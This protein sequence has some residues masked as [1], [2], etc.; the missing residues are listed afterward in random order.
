MSLIT[1]NAF[2]GL[3]YLLGSNNDQYTKTPNLGLNL[4]DYNNKEQ[5]I[6]IDGK[7]SEI[8]RTTPQLSAVIYKNA[9][10]L[11]NGVFVHYDKN[12]EVI[13]DSKLV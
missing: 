5:Y 3:K 2:N 12:G 9:Q 7:E 6:S 13:E 11:S 4:Y 10:M 8:F 1:S